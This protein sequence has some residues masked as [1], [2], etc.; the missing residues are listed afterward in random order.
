MTP[1]S[2]RSRSVQSEQAGRFGRQLGPILLLTSIFFLNFISRIILAPLMPD[3]VTRLHLSNVQAGSF[4]FFISL[5]YFSTLL[6]SGFLSA[7]LTHKKTITG[8]TVALGLALFIISLGQE[9]WSIRLGLILLG[10]AAGPYIPS[11]IATLTTLTTSAHWG[12]AIAIHELAPNLGFIVAPLLVEA[13][14][15][16]FSW[17]AV[18]V[19]LGLLAWIL[20]IIF[21]RFGRGGEFK[22]QLP[23]VASMKAIFSN[24][25]FWIMVVLFSLG[26]SGTLGIFTMLPLYLVDEH[27]FDRNWANTLIAL[28]RI[29]G[30][31]VVFFGGWAADR[32]GPRRI[33]RIVF[34]LSGLLTFLLGM[35]STHWL[36]AIIILQP[37]VA[38]CFFPAG[39]A[40]ISMITSPK[41]R[42]IAVSLTVPLAFLFGGGAIPAMIGFIGDLGSF[43]WGFSLV[44]IF[45]LI[46]ALLPG[47]LKF[48]SDSRK[49]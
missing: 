4:F 28:S 34:I 18:F 26:I 1:S 2:T 49:M 45:I 6:G 11:G 30:M 39:L 31:G 48:Y 23:N 16:Q 38:V 33:L 36:T 46:G 5:G 9:I 22:G 43:K 21:A 44:G 35:A 47:Y 17:R 8:S 19:L 10:M 12:K 27:G 37:V 42:N 40:A 13:M 24:P 41:E 25:T 3:M 29:A 15:L 20:G 32:F 14:L 7:Y